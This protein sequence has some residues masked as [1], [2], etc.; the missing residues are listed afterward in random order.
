[1]TFRI[2][3]TSW[4][5]QSSFWDL[6]L[7][8]RIKL[9][10]SRRAN[11]AQVQI[12]GRHKEIDLSKKYLCIFQKTFSSHRSKRMKNSAKSKVEKQHLQPLKSKLFKYQQHRQIFSNQWK[13]EEKQAKKFSLEMRVGHKRIPKL[14]T[15]SW[16]NLLVQI[17]PMMKSQKFHR[18]MKKL[19]STN[20]WISQLKSPVDTHRLWDKYKI[21]GDP[22]NWILIRKAKMLRISVIQIDLIKASITLSSLS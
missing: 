8:L 19:K 11:Q 14:S 5:M 1:M 17:D 20:G 2:S 7:N 13:G 10:K 15:L 12:K 22:Q 9:P 3:A 4:R 16:N 6:M 21:L 18:G